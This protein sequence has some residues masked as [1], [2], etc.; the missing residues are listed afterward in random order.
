MSTETQDM[1][2]G[3]SS[4]CGAPIYTDWQICTDCK[5]HCGDAEEE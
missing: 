4:C 3:I 1:K 5:E 2:G